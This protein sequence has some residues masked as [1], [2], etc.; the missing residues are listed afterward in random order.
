MTA[1]LIHRR[2]TAHPMPSHLV[3]MRQTHRAGLRAMYGLC[4]LVSSTQ[5]SFVLLY[6]LQLTQHQLITRGLM[7][8]LQHEQVRAE[9]TNCT[10]VLRMKRCGCK[11]AAEVVR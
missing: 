10:A 2:T 11:G 7:A 4:I 8:S 1:Q 9:G 6:S 3:A 5:G